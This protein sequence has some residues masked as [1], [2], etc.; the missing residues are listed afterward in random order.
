MTQIKRNV[1]D[2]RIAF[3]PDIQ[4]QHF[5]QGIIYDRSF[6][7]GSRHQIRLRITISLL[8]PITRVRR[9]GF[10]REGRIGNGSQPV[11]TRSYGF[12]E[13]VRP[14]HSAARRDLMTSVICSWLWQEHTLVRTAFTV[15]I[16]DN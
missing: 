7:D 14:F 3:M 16:K 4:A 2:L 1:S 13:N 8:M 11:P 9:P 6:V 12:M 5:S 15:F 10:S